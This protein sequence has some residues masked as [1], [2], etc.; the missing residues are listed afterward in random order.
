MRQCLL[1][2]LDANRSCGS[3]KNIHHSSLPP[4]PV[5]D[6]ASSA[7]LPLVKIKTTPRTCCLAYLPAARFLP[8]QA[9]NSALAIILSERQEFIRES[10]LS[11]IYRPK[12][13]T[14]EHN[15]SGNRKLVRFT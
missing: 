2:N 15:S 5:L 6:I 4:S 14:E 12:E 8:R 10:T 13:S 3:L 9:R 7:A 1:S 11:I